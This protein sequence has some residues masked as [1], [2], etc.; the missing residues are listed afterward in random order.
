VR[1]ELKTRGLNF[2]SIASH[3]FAMS[4]RGAPPTWDI[5]KEGMMLLAHQGGLSEYT[6][7]LQHLEKITI[8]DEIIT[9]RVIQPEFTKDTTYNMP[10]HTYMCVVSAH[11]VIGGVPGSRTISLRS[12]TIR[13]KRPIGVDNLVSTADTS[14]TKAAIK[15]ALGITKN[16]IQEIARELKLDPA[17]TATVMI[18][19]DVSD[20]EEVT[21]ALSEEEIKEAK[22]KE[23][24]LWQ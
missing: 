15:W 1:Q 9:E 17:K 12:D 24:A 14:A 22:A 8:R 2:S 19:E 4:F 21:A 16:D 7:T 3:F 20:D 11:V 5:D 23:D 18:P 6:T 13:R 10:T